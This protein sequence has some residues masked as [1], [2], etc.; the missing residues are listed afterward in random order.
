MRG[1][2]SFPIQ[3]S[4]KGPGTKEGSTELDHRL[5]RPPMSGWGYRTS[6]SDCPGASPR[7]A[8]RRPVPTKGSSLANYRH[9]LGRMLSTGPWQGR[10]LW[11]TWQ[12]LWSSLLDE[13]LLAWTIQSRRSMGAWS[14]C[15]RCN[16]TGY[17]RKSD[18]VWQPCPDCSAG[19]RWTSGSRIPRRIGDS[20]RSRKQAH[21]WVNVRSSLCRS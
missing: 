20:G 15:S 3:C 10:D 1:S 18:S 5:M 21:R 6:L 4:Q 7:W 8:P 2:C 17:L 11:G 14:Y 19:R 9:G 12:M 16:A 13:M